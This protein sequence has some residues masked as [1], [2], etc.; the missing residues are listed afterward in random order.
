MKIAFLIPTVG[1]GGA[2][3]VIT[4][5]ANFWAKKGHTVIL[6]SL[7]N[8]ANPPFFKLNPEVQYYPLDLLK[9]ERNYLRKF[10][11]T[12][13]QMWTMRKQV[14]KH[15]PN[16]LIAQLDIAIFL[17]VAS[18]LLLKE[19]V[20][21]YEGTNPYLSKTNKYLKKLN[22]FLYRFADHIVLQTQQI[23]NTFP[24]H[25]QDKISVIYNPI[26]KPKLQ[27]QSE[28]YAKNFEH[29]K[30]VSVGRLVP[31]KAFDVLIKAFHTFAQ[32]R[33][34]WTL[35]ILGEGEERQKLETLCATLNITKQV[36]LP[37]RVNDPLA[38]LKDC[39]IFVL[40][41]RYEGLPNALCEAMSIGLPVVATRCKFGPEEIIQHR[42]NGLLVPIEDASAISEALEE[43][44]SD[45]NLCEQLGTNAKDIVNVC[46]I[47]KV[48]QQWEDVIKKLT[49]RT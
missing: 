25:L 9:D 13:V 34:D 5:M 37:G 39:T 11:R 20:I 6:F 36:V 35:L 1:A 23:A 40:S 19:K 17:S 49:T 38:L 44:A 24:S 29:K 26:L 48:M 14:R 22:N 18:T 47:E 16:V 46:S 27:L 21:V 30:I 31:P 7:D 10:W 8:P 32:K 12:I 33:P 15:S 28:D 4:L 43:L 41:S 42:K 3:R 45:V 2:E